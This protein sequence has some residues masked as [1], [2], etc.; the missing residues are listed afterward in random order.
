M[1]MSIHKLYSFYVMS[2]GG[3]G[4]GGTPPPTTT[5][6]SQGIP[7]ELKP[8]ASAYTSKAMNLADTPFTPYGGQRYE[9]LNH[10]QNAGIGMVQN[11]AMNGS[12]VMNQANQ[13]LTQSL[14]GGQANPYLDS[15]VNKAQMSVLGNARA[16]DMRSGSFGNSGIAEQAATKMG[17]IATNMYGGAYDADRGRQMQA[18]GL[19]PTFGN[20]AYQD[21][22]QLMKA[23]QIQQDQG[24][25]N[26]D[27][28][29]SQF[30]EQQNKP[31]KDLA[32]MSGVFGS[33]LG[34][35]ST[36]T[37]SGGQAPGGK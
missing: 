7:A 21:A 35:T 36:S 13:T 17:D 5:V 11:R 26:R 16:A 3:G 22:S 14:Q 20:Q 25:Q 37:Q 10:T 31:Y 12:P 1:K 24:Q 28:G 30:Q 4:G 15:M 9:D 6:S 27:F 23:G 29:Y 32:A 33:N 18:L 2:M 8:L 19:A 34:N